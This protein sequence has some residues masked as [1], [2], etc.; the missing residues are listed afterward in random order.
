MQGERR[1]LA[2]DYY[3]AEASV[4]QTQVHS[5]KWSGRDGLWRRE[6]GEE[7][8]ISFVSVRTIKGRSINIH[9]Y[10][11]VTMWRLRRVSATTFAV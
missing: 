6:E 4:L 10:W 11:T 2:K 3:L 7:R 9:I 5:S 1:G 8:C